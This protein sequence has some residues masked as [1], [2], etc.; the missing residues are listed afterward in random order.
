MGVDYKMIMIF[1]NRAKVQNPI[2]NHYILR[3]FWFDLH[4]YF[5]ICNFHQKHNCNA[6]TFVITQSLALFKIKQ[7]AI[8]PYQVAYSVQN[9]CGHKMT[10]SICCL[11]DIFIEM[12]VFKIGVNSKNHN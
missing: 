6:K 4:S 8:S 10:N 11:E 9:R 2:I 5:Y 7:M 12:T 3:Q 1:E